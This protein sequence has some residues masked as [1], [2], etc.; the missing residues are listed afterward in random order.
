M[1]T[2]VDAV[3]IGTGLG[4]LSAATCLAKN[5]LNVLALERHNVPG[6]Y[7]TSFV[8]G[9][10]EFE[11]A[12]HELSGIGTQEKTGGMYR[13]LD[14]L[15]VAS[16]VEFVQT[17]TLYRSIFPGVDITLSQG[18]DQYH[19]TMSDAF[20]DQSDGIAKLLDICRRVYRDLGQLRKA[21]FDKVFSPSF[22]LTL[23]FR[24]PTLARYNQA[25]WAPVLRRFVTD[26]RAQAVL[27]Q[28]WGYFGLPPEL[29]SFFYFAVGL[30][31]YIKHGA[32]Y[33][34]GRSQALSNA[35]VETLEEHGGQARFGCAVERILTEDGQVTGVLTDQGERIAATYVISNT[36]PITT[37]CDLIDREQVPT[38]F[39]RSLQSNNLAT[40]TV[41]VYLGVARSA[42]QLGI[43]DHEIFINR[44]MDFESH[45][46]EG[47]VVNPPA[48]IAMTCYNHV[49]PEI[50]PPGTSLLTLTG[51]S[52]GRA[53]H[54][55][56]PQDYVSEK[57]RVADGM[58]KM[59]ER[60][61]PD[62]RQYA[63]VVEVATPL[64][65][66][67]Y[68]NALGGSIYGFDNAPGRHT[69]WRMPARGPVKG[70]YF[71]GAWTQPGGG[72][73]PVMISGELAAN[74]VLRRV[75]KTQEVA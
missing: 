1:D 14:S 2:H 57:H 5:G 47:E 23:P 74:A 50:S 15:G 20:P 35:F 45:F 32:T 29:C 12:L 62:L 22:A 54:Q 56:P 46:R 18:W 27:S 58:I 28:Y 55:V 21:G 41:N 69:L 37:C 16:K 3:V 19:Q 70:L 30:A 75:R 48:G 25:V 51:M 44:D 64:T 11:V 38:E 33:V 53:W 60:I 67:R 13:Y 71:A 6:G 43:T 8:R 9:R 49:T 10:Y 40:S 66:V 39:F 31:S 34:R 24:C 36:D 63:E 73:E 17:P 68:A 72:F 61:C 26:E 42:E 4:G 59:A 7:A 52:F 65:N